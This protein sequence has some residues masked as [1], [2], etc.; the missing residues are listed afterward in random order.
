M[1]CVYSEGSFLTFIA[2]P[3]FNIQ[4]RQKAENSYRYFSSDNWEIIPY[5]YILSTNTYKHRD[6]SLPV[7]YLA[8][9]IYTFGSLGSRSN[10]MNICRT[11]RLQIQ[12]CRYICQLRCDIAMSS[13]RDLNTHKAAIG[14]TI[15]IKKALQARTMR[16]IRNCLS[17][18]F[19]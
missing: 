17:Q 1:I 16:C 2:I 7:K 8:Q 15:Q 14:I 19:V 9:N 18:K 11:F 5:I 10:Q 12:V 3:A 4:L 13:V 6:C